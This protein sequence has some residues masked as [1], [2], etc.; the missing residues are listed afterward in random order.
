MNR[1]AIRNSSGKIVKRGFNNRSEARESRENGEY[2]TKD[3]DHMKY[4]I[5]YESSIHPKR[6]GKSITKYS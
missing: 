3:S 5:K 1:Y 2:I 4:G 6:K